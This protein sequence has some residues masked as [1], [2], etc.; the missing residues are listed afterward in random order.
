[1]HF[2][3]FILCL[4][5]RTSMISTNVFFRFFDV[6]DFQVAPG[7]LAGVDR[8][9]VRVEKFVARG[10]SFLAVLFDGDEWRQTLSGHCAGRLARHPDA[11]PVRPQRGGGG[12][13]RCLRRRCG[14]TGILE[15]WR[16]RVP[17]DAS[18]G[19][20]HLH[21][22]RR[23]ARGDQPRRRRHF[24]VVQREFFGP[25]TCGTNQ[26]TLVPATAP[27][28]DQCHLPQVDGVQFVQKGS[29]VQARHSEIE[30]IQQK[31][32]LVVDGVLDQPRQ[33]IRVLAVGV[34]PFG[35]LQEKRH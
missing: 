31:S 27:G 1:M 18:S 29:P 34:V 33:S 30:T 20:H 17:R 14:G 32:V 12:T 26:T 4:N 11:R 5:T 16:P 2:F 28:P 10:Q 9:G 25:G 6:T 24:L 35:V 3:K 21:P 22:H 15:P 7:A 23:V 8:R 19:R 13:D